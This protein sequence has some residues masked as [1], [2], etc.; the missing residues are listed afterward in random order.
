MIMNESFIHTPCQLIFYNSSSG[1]LE[2][3]SRVDTDKC[4]L[5]LGIVCNNVVFA[6]TDLGK[7]ALAGFQAS[8]T[9]LAPIKPEDT[10][11][12]VGTIHETLLK[13]TLAML[14]FHCTIDSNVV[15]KPL[16]LWK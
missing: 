9:H 16:F 7:K 6:L 8:E 2:L 12:A 15:K 4:H 5:V 10:P 11:K 13:K 3:A 1:G 14:S